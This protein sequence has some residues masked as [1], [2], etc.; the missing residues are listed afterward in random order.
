MSNHVLTDGALYY[1]LA[2]P[3]YAPPSVL[4]VSSAGINSIAVQEDHQHH[5]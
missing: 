4:Q 3:R 1:L 2:H 5:C